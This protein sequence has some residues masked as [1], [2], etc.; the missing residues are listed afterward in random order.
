MAKKTVFRRASKWLS[1]S[2]ELRDAV[3]IDDNHFE[4]SLPVENISESAPASRTDVAK[5]V[6][7][8]RQQ[9]QDENVEQQPEP[10]ESQDAVSEDEVNRLVDTLKSL[11][12]DMAKRAAIYE[13]AGCNPKTK[14][15]PRSGV[16]AVWDVIS[17]INE[18]NKE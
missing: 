15:W 4:H 10:E 13:Q 5:R 2:S 3:S 12:P 1:L 16:E 7:Q 11:E 9:T 18:A 14:L 8:Q 17:E 6:V